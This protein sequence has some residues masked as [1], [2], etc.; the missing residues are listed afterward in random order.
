[1]GQAVP[2][3]AEP[4]TVARSSRCPPH[5]GKSMAEMQRRCR[6]HN[7]ATTDLNGH[8]A[9]PSSNPAE[10]EG[11]LG[12]KEPPP[13]STDRNPAPNH[14]G[15][16]GHFPYSPTN[17]GTLRWG[18]NTHPNNTSPTLSFLVQYFIIA[19][20]LCL[21][22]FLIYVLSPSLQSIFLFHKYLPNLGFVKASPLSIYILIDPDKTHSFPLQQDIFYLATFFFSFP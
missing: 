20:F 7:P 8:P 5:M 18:L 17:S 4:I 15:F 16:L 9:L 10:W 21:L 14:P 13:K 1:V 3:L 22:A 6:N 12:H 19:P 11:P 2:I